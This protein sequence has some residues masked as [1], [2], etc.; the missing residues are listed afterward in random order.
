MPIEQE[1]ETGLYDPEELTGIAVERAALYRFLASIFQQEMTIDLLTRILND[2]FLAFLAGVGADAGSLA[3]LVPGKELEEEL[4]Q[5][6]TRLFIG[7][8]RH[9]SPYESVHLGGDSGSLWGP[10]TT[11][12]KKFIESA[13]STYTDIYRDLPDHISV[14]LEFM[15]QLTEIEAD[16]WRANNSSKALN[17][18]QFQ[19]EF[20]AHHLGRWTHSFSVRVE[21]LAEHPIY[22]QMAL[23]VRNFVDDEIKEL[24]AQNGG[25]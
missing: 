23:V 2:K 9:V 8:G 21:E 19:K 22:P 25:S 12:L 18:I 3:T 13:G 11:A 14:E 1:D 7:P 4:S 17:S 5:E 10:Q 20:L 16:A 6:Y 15:A 24:A